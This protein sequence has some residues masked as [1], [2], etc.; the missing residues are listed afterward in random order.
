METFLQRHCHVLIVNVE[1]LTKILLQEMF[2][3]ATITVDIF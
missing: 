3:H 2:K 1:G